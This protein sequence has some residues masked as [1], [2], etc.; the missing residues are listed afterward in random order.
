MGKSA[1]N[2]DLGDGAV[3]PRRGQVQGGNT[4]PEVHARPPLV[5]LMGINAL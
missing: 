1:A 4:R 2:T 5:L 3:K